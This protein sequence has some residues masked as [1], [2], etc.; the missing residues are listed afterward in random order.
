MYKGLCV[1]FLP[2]LSAT[3]SAE[4]DNSTNTTKIDE[5]SEW[6]LKSYAPNWEN[7]ALENIPS[8]MKHYASTY[9]F[10]PLSGDIQYQSNT[11]EHW[12][13]W[14]QLN[15]DRGWH[16]GQVSIDIRMINTNTAHID[17]HWV[18]RDSKGN[19]VTYCDHAIASKPE[20]RW[21]FV[22]FAECTPHE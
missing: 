14:V 9:M 1:V 17:T 15:I 6:Y 3:Y 13:P 7:P 5:V 19:D 11:H 4:A 22:L 21:V 16:E 20:D 8:I 12:A 2:L 10:V 18:Y